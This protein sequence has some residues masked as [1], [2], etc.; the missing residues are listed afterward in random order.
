MTIRVGTLAFSTVQGIGLLARD[1]HRHGVITEVV[2]VAHGRREEHPE[3]FPGAF[4]V[5]NF[6]DPKQRR[7]VL[8]WAASLDVFLAVETPHFWEIIPHCRAAGVKT[9]ILCMYECSHERPPYFADAYLCPSLLDVQYFS[10]AGV[11]APFERLPGI[12]N[13]VAMFAPI[14]VDVPW[15]QRTRAEVF[16]H[17]AGHGGLKGRNGTAEL[18]EAL[19]LVKSPVKLILR[20]QDRMPVQAH[21]GRVRMGNVEV[22]ASSG[23]LEEKWLYDAG[24]VFLFPEKFNGLSLPL[25]EARA[26]GMLVMCGDRFPMSEWLPREPLIP[27]AGYRKNRIGPP[28]HEFSEAVF[29]PKD[30]AATIDRWYGRDITEYS[31]SGKAWAESMSWAKL[32]PRYL[33]VLESLCA[34]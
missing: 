34:S 32:R 1:F 31:A 28:Y 5:T 26:A 30:I 24:D 27:V 9:A 33:E 2:T 10:G 21:E 20:S 22:F 23:T 12:S 11:A 8:E 6:R 3:W 7:A 15:R 19:P 14:P 29:D 25:Q 13:T 17:N 4:H 16:V 18:L